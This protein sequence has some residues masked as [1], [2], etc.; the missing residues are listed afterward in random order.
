MEVSRINNYW[1]YSSIKYALYV[2]TSFSNA[3]DVHRPIQ[4]F[5]VLSVLGFGKRVI[6]RKFIGEIVAYNYFVGYVAKM[7]VTLW[8]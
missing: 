1:K 3:R 2:Y 4:L 8:L 5:F 7:F 6:G